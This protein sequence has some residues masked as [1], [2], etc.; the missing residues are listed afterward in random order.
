MLMLSRFASLIG[1]S[2]QILVQAQPPQILQIYR[3]PLKPGVHASYA[4][5]ELLEKYSSC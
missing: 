4:E 5:I 3:D 2:M 1:F